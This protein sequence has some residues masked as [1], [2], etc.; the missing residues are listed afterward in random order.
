MYRKQTNKQTNKHINKQNIKSEAYT[1]SCALLKGI[2]VS[3][4]W[5]CFRTNACHI[6]NRVPLLTV[7]V[8]LHVDGWV[9]SKPLIVVVLQLII[10][11]LW[12]SASKKISVTSLV[13]KWLTS[14]QVPRGVTVMMRFN[15]SS[16]ELS[17]IWCWWNDNFLFRNL[18]LD[19]IAVFM[20][21]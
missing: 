2:R 21:F 1:S 16:D 20:Q 19:R 9:L 3:E 12:L 6:I 11:W 13:G 14:Y 15:Q 8:N 17:T 7:K 5:I 10:Q 4:G 18:S